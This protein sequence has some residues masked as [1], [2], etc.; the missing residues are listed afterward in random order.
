[1]SDG[2]GEGMTSAIQTEGLAKS[3]S[4]IRVHRVRS[5]TDPVAAV[6]F[7]YHRVREGTA[8][9]ATLFTCPDV[10]PRVAAMHVRKMAPA[11]RHATTSPH[12]VLIRRQA[13]VGHST[14]ST[15]NTIEPGAD[16]LSFAAAYTRLVPTEG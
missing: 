7:P 1:M 14:G 9:P 2:A 10:D 13:D 3:F 4:G 12:P 5:R 16:I 11:L 6:L 15:S 8:Y